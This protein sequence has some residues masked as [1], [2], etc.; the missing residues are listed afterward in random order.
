ML[1]RVRWEGFCAG[2]PVA[3]DAPWVRV[4]ATEDLGRLLLVPEDWRDA[5]GRGR[6]ER[7]EERGV[8]VP[9]GLSGWV[10]GD[11]DDGLLCVFTTTQ[12]PPWLTC[13]RF[14]GRSSG[15]EWDA[16]LRYPSSAG[17]VPGMGVLSLSPLRSSSLSFSI[18][19]VVEML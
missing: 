9:D 1:A 12:S 10:Q 11:G 4:C 3:M 13:C 17:K 18:P 7:E 6:Y 8:A 19:P 14:A 2:E 5:T 15:G 16:M